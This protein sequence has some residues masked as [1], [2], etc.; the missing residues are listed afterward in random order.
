MRKLSS[1][2]LA[3]LLMSLPAMAAVKV[4]VVNFP[5]ALQET[6]QGQAAKAALEKEI[7]EKKKKLD[8]ER[9]A[10][11]KEQEAFQKG[12]A[13]MAEK[14]RNEKGLA[15][16]KKIGAWQEAAQRAQVEM[17]QREG[18]A[19]RPIVENLRKLISEVGRRRGLDLVLEQNSVLFALETQD[20]TD[21]LIKLY[22]EKNPASKKK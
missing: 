13:V 19:T 7:T 12:A 20:V 10:L 16:Q 3:T 1:A 21:E 15:L 17:Q 8:E 6:A 2:L 14:A 5:R 22:D 18:E 4:G 11:E 9:V